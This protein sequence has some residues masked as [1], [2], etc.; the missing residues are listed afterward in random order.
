MNRARFFSRS[1]DMG[2]MCLSTK[3]LP[4]GLG[5]LTGAAPF[6]ACPSPVTGREADNSHGSSLLPAQLIWHQR[7]LPKRQ[8][9]VAGARTCTM[10]V[11]LDPAPCVSLCWRAGCR[12]WQGQVQW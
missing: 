3:S 4:V 10:F 9:H 7:A 2:L 11:I 8:S 6:G 12:I 1:S 5:L